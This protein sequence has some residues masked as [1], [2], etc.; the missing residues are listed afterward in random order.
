MHFSDLIRSNFCKNV[1]IHFSE[2]K[3]TEEWNLWA[4][5]LVQWLWQDSCSRDRGFES[6]HRMLDRHDHDMLYLKCIACLKNTQN[7]RKRGRDSPPLNRMREMP[8][9]EFETRNHSHRSCILHWGALKGNAVSQN[10]RRQNSNNIW[11]N[12][13]NNFNEIFGAD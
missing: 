13:G 10:S 4:G 6:L 1:K 12:F 9:H 8:R 11:P 7:K 5:T 2:P 3:M